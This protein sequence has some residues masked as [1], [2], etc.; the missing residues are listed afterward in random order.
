[1][2]NAFDGIISRPDTTH[3]RIHELEEV[4][5]LKCKGRRGRGRRRRRRKR[6]HREQK[7][8]EIISKSVT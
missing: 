8:C 6:Q 4:L 7:N 5:T 1:M 3:K 2:K